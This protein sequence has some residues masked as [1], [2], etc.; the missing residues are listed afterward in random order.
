MKIVRRALV[1]GF[2]TPLLGAA[3]AT[4]VQHDWLIVPGER[5]GPVSADS[6]AAGLRRSLGED[7]VTNVSIGMGEG[8]RE[9]GTI[10]YPDDPTHSLAILWHDDLRRGGDELDTGPVWS[11]E[12]HRVVGDFW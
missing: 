8:E 3:G 10:I 7:L 12:R 9:E 11:D 4:P 5:V 6:T 1:A 2:L